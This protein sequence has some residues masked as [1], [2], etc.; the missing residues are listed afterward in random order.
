MKKIP[1]PLQVNLEKQG[2]STC[3]LV[4]IVCKDGDAL[5][6]CS[7][8]ADLT[9]NDGEHNLTYDSAQELFPQNLQQELDYSVDNTDLLGW[10]NSTMETQ[11]LAGKFDFAE[12]T[13]YR[14]AYLVLS[15]GVEVLAYGTVGEIDFMPTSD[16]KRKVEYRGLTQQLKTNV[17]QPWSLTC[18]AEFGDDRCGMPFVWYNGTVSAVGDDP[19]TKFTTSGVAQPDDY[20]VLGVIEFLTGDNAGKELEVESWLASGIVQLSFLAPYPVAIGDTFRIR[21]DC[22]K[23]ETSCKNYG[24][25][26]NMRAE[27]KTPVQDQAIMVPGAYI[28]SVGSK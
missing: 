10:F 27:S 16:G 19:Y 11:V 22:D 20:F 5:G 2:T 17:S 8:D 9:F 12:V 1:T 7:L 21:Q 25:I 14:C 3:F 6:F 18:R 26:I 4:K 28:K 24:N 13:I 15:S 23:T